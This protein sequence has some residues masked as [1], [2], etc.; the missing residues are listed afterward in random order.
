[1]QTALGRS[2][3]AKIPIIKTTTNNSI[4][5]KPFFIKHLLAL[6]IKPPKSSFKAF[7][8]RTYGRVYPR[9]INNNLSKKIGQARLRNPAKNT[10]NPKGT[11]PFLTDTFKNGTTHKHSPVF[12][13][14]GGQKVSPGKAGGV[15]ITN[16][17]SALRIKTLSYLLER[18]SWLHFLLTIVEDSVFFT[19]TGIFSDGLRAC[20]CASA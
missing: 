19:H 7:L 18:I 8:Q 17:S 20:A 16:Y 1:M 4:N 15:K 9:H 14:P 2:M 10:N 6:G 5:V 12:S 13:A 3:L 11:T